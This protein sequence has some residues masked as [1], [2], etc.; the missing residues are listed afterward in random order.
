MFED[1]VQIHRGTVP[2]LISVPHAGTRL[3]PAVQAGLVEAASG[4]PDTDWHIP[5][6][7]QVARDLGASMVA[8]QYSR[9]VIDLNRPADD[10]PLYAGTTTGLYPQMLFDGTPLYR[11]GHE[12]S[13][14]ERENYLEHIWKPYHQA[15]QDELARLRAQFG[16]AVL[17]DA[18]SIRSQLPLL[19][20][21]RLPD[22]NLGNFSGASCAGDLM[23]RLQALCAGAEGYSHSVNGR[24]KGGHITRHYGRPAEHIHSVQLELSQRNY[25]DEQAPF[26]YREDLAAPLQVVLKALL[27]EVLSWGREQY[28]A[29]PMEN[30]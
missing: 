21:G 9:F 10:T 11:P 6:L 19:F 23:Q 29:P 12:P 14:A 28:R 1:T 25:M 2:L 5:R 8:G 16:Y 3:T 4:V 26:G 20:E 7:Y 17:W 24:F 30:L 22:L 27:E 15:V 18:H 13:A